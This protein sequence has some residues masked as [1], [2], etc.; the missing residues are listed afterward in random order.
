MPKRRNTHQRALVREA[1]HALDGHPTAEE[2]YTYVRTQDPR[3]SRATV[4]RNLG[5]LCE[6]GQLLAVQMPGC[7]HYDYRVDEH[8]H[9]LCTHCGRIEDVPLEGSYDRSLD[10]AVAESSGYAVL[11]HDTVFRGLCPACQEA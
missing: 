5:L 3:I 6:E 4:Y 8:A 1:V 7:Y 10:T 2:V 9:L 11:G